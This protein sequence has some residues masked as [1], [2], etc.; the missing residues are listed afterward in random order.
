M[1]EESTSECG[2]RVTGQAPVLRKI[3]FICENHDS[4]AVERV[5]DNSK[6]IGPA[7]GGLR[8]GHGVMSTFP[9]KD[10]VDI[11]MTIAG[12]LAI[13]N[14]LVSKNCGLLSP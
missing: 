11:G 6:K 5:N 2:S 13:V 10:R 3:D 4:G 14:N 12:V 9:A 8:P 7:A 1:S